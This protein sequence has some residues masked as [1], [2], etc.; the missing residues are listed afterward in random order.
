MSESVYMQ[1]TMDAG[2][3]ARFQQAAAHERRPAAQ[4]LQALMREYVARH[5]GAG[6]VPDAAG[7]TATWKQWCSGSRGGIPVRSAW[8][9]GHGARSHRGRGA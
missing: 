2:L 4:V 8:G 3:R 6:E 7:A 5:A 9:D 1:V